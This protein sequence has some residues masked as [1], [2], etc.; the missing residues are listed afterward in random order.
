MALLLRLAGVPW[1]GAIGVD[2]PG[3]LLDVCAHVD[4][5]LHEVRRNLSLAAACGFALPPGDDEG[6]RCIGLP[7]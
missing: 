6:L 1:I 5:D 7:A 3:S 4:D 2:Y